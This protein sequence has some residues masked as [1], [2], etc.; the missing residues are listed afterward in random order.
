MNQKPINITSGE[1]TYVGES[2]ALCILQIHQ[3]YDYL[4]QA[5]AKYKL[6]I[7]PQIVETHYMNSWIFFE[8]QSRVELLAKVC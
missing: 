5:K 6:T 1:N 2:C 7:C 8:Q 4:A 3:H